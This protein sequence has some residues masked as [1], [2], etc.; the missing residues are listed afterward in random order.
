MAALVAA[1]TALQATAEATAKTLEENTKAIA[2]PE[3][4]SSSA[5]KQVFGD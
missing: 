3:Q 1:V 2:F 5:G 4:S